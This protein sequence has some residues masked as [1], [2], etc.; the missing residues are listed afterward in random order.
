MKTI[1]FDNAATT[2]LI[3]EVVERMKIVLSDIFGNPSSVHGVGRSAK[4][5]VE[6]ARKTIAAQFNVSPS[7][8]IFTSGGTEGDNMILQSAVRQLGVKTL[9]TSALEHHAVLHAAEALEKETNIQIKYVKHQICGS[10][11]YDH[12]ESLLSNGREKKLVSLMHI[13][14]EV[15]TK[16]D[17]DRVAKLC[18]RYHT[19][20]HSDTVQSIGH[21]PLDLSSIPIDFCVGAAHKFHGPK[22]VGFAFIRKKSGLGSLIHGGAQERGLRAGT[23]PVH[24]IAGLETAFK[25]AYQNLEK[26]THTITDLKKYCIKR[27]EEVFPDVQYNGKCLDFSNSTYTILNVRLPISQEKASLLTF[28]LDLNGIA[29]SKGSACQAGSDSGS[30]VL[31]ALLDD[32]Q[33]KLPSV[34]IS[35]SK[36]NTTE[37][38]DTFVEVLSAYATS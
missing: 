4:A 21:Y 35:F 3:P 30:H 14:N 6:T 24:N 26:D 18:K 33:I 29:C 34:R 1:Y 5:L 20:F 15:G 12:L 27:L 8:I 25:M 16:M 10:P 23:E 28:H 31:Q 7:E 2:G 13:N 22:G 36:F 38:I 19:L 32:E 11:D 37:E 9:I 17:L